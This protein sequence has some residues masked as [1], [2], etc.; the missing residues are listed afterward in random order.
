MLAGLI[1]F[2]TSM[3]GRA[4][5]EVD[6]VEEIE[7]AEVEVVATEGPVSFWDRDHPVLDRAVNLHLAQVSRPGSLRLIIDHRTNTP[8]TENVGHDFFGFDTGAL[9]I[10]LG[11]R[12]GLLRDLDV[13]AYRLNNATLRF[14]VYEFDAKYHLLK[15]ER[16]GV[17][18]GLRAGLSWFVQEAAEDAVGYLGQLL[19]NRTF[20]SRLT[21]GTGFL[22]HSNSTN[23]VK[24]VTD[25]DWS[26]ATY[27]LADIRILSWLSWNAE[28]AVSL[29]GYGSHDKSDSR[30][31]ALTSWPSWSSSV[32]FETHRH[33]FGI[34]VGNNPF[35]SADGV[36]SNSTRGPDEL[37][38]GFAITREWS[39]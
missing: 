29:A 28:A 15:Q 36:V 24:T 39:N 4:D 27:A 5:E 35:M 37:V 19:A 3:D 26:L 7:L 34:V 10:G 18:L 17:D 12:Y 23:D 11:L 32:R 1:A 9:K 21:L 8:F 14:D 20:I 33:T 30:G 6:E 22:F 31:E 13:G 25:K 16:L 38:V 2:W